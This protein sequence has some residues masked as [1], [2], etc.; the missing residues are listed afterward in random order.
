ME[1]SLDALRPIV[2][3]LAHLRAAYAH[4]FSDLDLVE[5]TREFFPDP[6]T[7]EPEAID[8]LLRRMMTYAPLSTNLRVQIHYAFEQAD[9]AEGHGANRCGSG[10]CSSPAENVGRSRA[11]AWRGVME[12]DEGYAVA[13]SEHDISDPA[14]LAA[15]L[16]RAVGRIVLFEANE[17][18][19]SG[20]GAEPF[21]SELTAVSCGLGTLL[22]NASCIYKKGCGGLRRHQGTFVSVEELAF[23]CALFVRVRGVSP[24]RVHRHLA[25]TQQ[26]AFGHAL[27]WLHDQPNL[28]RTLV[29][30]PALVSDGIFAVEEK[31][32]WFA[33]IFSLGTSEA[34]P[35]A[36][37]S[38]PASTP[39]RSPPRSEQHKQRLAKLKQ[40]TEEAL[41]DS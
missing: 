21:L 23:A 36:E 31:K 41:H 30:Q 39:R 1:L 4:V 15:A 8:Q 22:F 18:I 26:E 25:A 6:I 19:P 13:L 34:M 40:L 3:H 9:T 38:M 12:T 37:I 5:P 16:A 28:V 17:A 20:A 27:R 33:R 10:A 24:N 35:E 2:A 14:L 11:A 32:S 29:E 7:L